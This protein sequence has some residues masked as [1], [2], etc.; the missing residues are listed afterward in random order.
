MRNLKKIGLYFGTFNPIHVGHLIIA[1]HLAENTN[2]DEVWM[3]ITPQSPFK[4]K[5][6]LLDNHHRLELVYRAVESFDKIKPC[7]I[8]FGMP[9]PNYTAK[10]LAVLS[11]K[12][13]EKQFSLIMGEDNL[14]TFHKWKNY[15]H[16]LREYQIYTCPRVGEKEIPEAFVNHPNIQFTDTPIIE[17]SATL[18]RNSIRDAKDVRPLLPNEVWKYIDEMNFYRS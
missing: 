17:I 5:K 13:P 9:T 4:K 3:V 15:E 7:A 11:E 1:N 10:T 16:I 2:L 8:E 12:Y 14:K 6:N 18:I